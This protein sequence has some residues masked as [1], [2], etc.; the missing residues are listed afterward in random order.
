MDSGCLPPI[1]L[2][3]VSDPGNQDELSTVV[4]GVDD[5][6]VA[7]TDPIVVKPCQPDRTS[8]PRIVSQMLNRT[9]D[10]TRKGIVKTPIRTRSVR[11]EPDPVHGSACRLP[12]DLG[13]G[14]R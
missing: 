3:A 9:G 10:A 12:A 2:T 8:R 4:D 5:P 1:H 11:L 6:V 13:P 7:D 14:Y